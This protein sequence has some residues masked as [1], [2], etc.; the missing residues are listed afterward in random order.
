MFLARGKVAVQSSG[1]YVLLDTDRGLAV[2]FDGNHYVSV[3]LP[4]SYRGQ[5]CGLCGELG[6]WGGGPVAPVCCCFWRVLGC[7]AAHKGAVQRQRSQEPVRG[8]VGGEHCALH[9]VSFL[10]LIRAPQATQLL[11]FLYLACRWRQQ[12]LRNKRFSAQQ[13]RMTEAAEPES[14]S[15]P[16]CR[17]T[18]G[19]LFLH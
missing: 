12:P 9:G 5:L 10:Q 18:A 8:W 7:P 3:S 14:S 2:R 13:H 17:H 15:G 16:R 6:A 19:G 11:W 1:N 4:L